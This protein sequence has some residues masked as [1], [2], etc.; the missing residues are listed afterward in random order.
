MKHKVPAWNSLCTY[1]MNMIERIQISNADVQPPG[2]VCL[3]KSKRKTWCH[4]V[5]RLNVTYEGSITLCSQ[6][7][8]ED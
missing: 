6:K 2:I 5:E 3:M 8:E 7:H 4:L 1:I